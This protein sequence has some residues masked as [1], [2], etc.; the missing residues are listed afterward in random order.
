MPDERHWVVRFLGAHLLHPWAEA[1]N[2]EDDDIAHL[3]GSLHAGESLPRD[4]LPIHLIIRWVVQITEN[5][6]RPDGRAGEFH[7][8]F[9]KLLFLQ[10]TQLLHPECVFGD[11][12]D[13]VAED[14]MAGF[15][16][17]GPLAKLNPARIPVMPVGSIGVCLNANDEANGGSGDLRRKPVRRGF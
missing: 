3:L 15:G 12:G 14:R 9:I 5:G 1:R 10:Y 4:V 11:G 17:N 16:L 7:D 13:N 2:G 8:A 6:I